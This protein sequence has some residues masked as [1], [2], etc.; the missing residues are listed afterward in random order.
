MSSQN[1]RASHSTADKLAKAINEQFIHNGSTGTFSQSEMDQLSETVE[2]LNKHASEA[3]NNDSCKAHFENTLVWPSINA[4]NYNR[5]LIQIVLDSYTVTRVLQLSFFDIS[6]YNDN[7][8]PRF[9]V[10]VHEIEELELLSK[11]SI[12]KEEYLINRRIMA[13]YNLIRLL[14]NIYTEDSNRYIAGGSET[15]IGDRLLETSFLL[16][17]I[18]NELN[19]SYSD[20]VTEYINKVSS[21]MDLTKPKI[22][23][24]KID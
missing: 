10:N 4:S 21:T 1:Q 13:E 16:N 11:G 5:R 7:H 12:S 8:Q 20:E 17:W 9:N 15:I 23:E 6:Q 2:I 22:L 24:S 3:A 14:P 19:H 18:D